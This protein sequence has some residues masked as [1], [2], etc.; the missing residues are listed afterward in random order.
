M[1]L[2]DFVEDFQPE[3]YVFERYQA[4]QEL[5][6]KVRANDEAWPDSL[7]TDAY[8]DV[9]NRADPAEGYLATLVREGGFAKDKTLASTLSRIFRKKA[10]ENPFWED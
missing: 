3:G 1:A 9:V 2:Q 6:D 4:L 7:S 8:S 5:F 10:D